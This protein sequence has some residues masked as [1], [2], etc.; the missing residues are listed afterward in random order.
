MNQAVE[1]P[2]RSELP[3]PWLRAETNAYRLDVG[4]L[5]IE[6]KVSSSAYQKVALRMRYNVCIEARMV[7]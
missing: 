3:K 1:Q 7:Q 4:V 6:I 5:F 2:A